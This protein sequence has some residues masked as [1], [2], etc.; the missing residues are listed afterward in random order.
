MSERL[1]FKLCDVLWTPTEFPGEEWGRVGSYMS[2]LAS[3]LRPQKLPCNL[4]SKWSPVGWWP[5]QTVHFDAHMYVFLSAQLLFTLLFF[6]F[7]SSIVLNWN[8]LHFL[9]CILSFYLNSLYMLCFCM[10]SPDSCMSS[11]YSDVIQYYKQM[12]VTVLRTCDVSG[13][14]KTGFI[15]FNPTVRFKRTEACCGWQD[16]LRALI[17]H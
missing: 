5:K 3:S 11:S 15:I 13:T 8:L 10:N 4:D 2:R 12:Y 1:D 16:V 7:I 6:C 9:F 17:S 14:R